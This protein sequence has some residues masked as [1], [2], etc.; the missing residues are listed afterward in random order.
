[1][2]APISP[3]LRSRAVEAWL[4]GEGT[5]REIAERFL[6]G[7]ASVRRWVALLRRTGGVTPKEPELSNLPRLVDQV[8]DGVLRELVAEHPDATEEELTD[9]FAER[10]DKHPS[11]STIHRALRR[12]RFTRKEKPSWRRNASPSVCRTCAGSSWRPSRPWIPSGPTTSTRPAPRRRWLATMAVATEG[13]VSGG[14]S[15]ATTAMS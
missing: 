14:P 6:V 11:R 10:T 9:L 4:G 15:L 5:Q 1:M 12:L 7:E 8:C 3:D 13:N 2:P